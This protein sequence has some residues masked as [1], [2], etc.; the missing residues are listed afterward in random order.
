MFSGCQFSLYPMSDNFVE[1][2]LPAV[3]AMGSP[4][5]LRIETDDIS[6]LVVGQPER[7]FEVVAKAYEA[8]CRAG[9]HVV[10]SALFS[11][12]CPGEPD[13]PLCTPEGPSKGPSN[14][15]GSDSATRGAVTSPAATTTTVATGVE[16]DAQFSLYPL[17]IPGYM[18]TIAATVGAVKEAGVY[19]R[20]KNFCTRLSGDLAAVFAAVERAFEEAARDTGHVVIHLTASKGSPSKKQNSD[21]M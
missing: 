10:L 15:A 21:S 5:D 4:K 1:V 11:R 3:K 9:G 16:I 2:I 13:D 18:N 7:V 6:T 19:D 20:S 14:G 17:G 8:A 12:G